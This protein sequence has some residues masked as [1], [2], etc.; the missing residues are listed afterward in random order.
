MKSSLCFLSLFSV[1]SLDAQL[2]PVDSVW[3]EQTL[4]SMSLDEK[5]GQLIMPPHLYLDESKE[6]IEKYHVGGFWFAKSEAVRIA[7][8]LNALQ[9]AS[10]YPLL[11]AAD[12]EKGAGT[13]VDGATDLPINMALGASR[14]PELAYRAAALTA[15]EA[16]AIGVHVNFAP[17]MDVNNNPDNPVINIRSYGEDPTLVAGLAEAA[18]RGYQ[19]NG[20]LATGKH[21]PGHGNTSV[22]SH[23]R[24]G[25]IE[26]NSA[27]MDSLE[28]L[29]Y[30]EVLKKNPPACIMSAHLWVKALDNDTIPATFS[31]N[32]L[33]LLLRGRLGFDGIIFPDAMVMGGLTSRY[34]SEE[35][36][37]R[38]IQAGC[39][40]LLWPPN[41]QTSFETLK[42]AVQSGDVSVERINQSVR[43]ILRA[44]TCVGLQ[45]N[46]SVDVEKIP[47]LVG[48]EA[49]YNEA[50]Q[51]AAKCL[52]LVKD[53]GKLLPLNIGQHVLV[54][55]MNN[56]GGNAMMS[57]TLVSFPSEL[58]NIS[59]RITQFNLPETI[60]DLDTQRA[61]DL[62]RQ[63]DVVVIA[64]YVRIFLG[65]GTVGLP[66]SQ[67]AFIEQMAL[68]NVKVVVV[69]FGNPYIGSSLPFVSTYVCAYDNAKALQ[70]TAAEALF[71]RSGF[72]GKLPVTISKTMK[73]G[74]GI[75]KK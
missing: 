68:A 72:G 20:I 61:L 5:I 59:P 15:K 38:T 75:E 29:P 42:N 40:I 64:A 73:F 14:D 28:L 19:Q 30:T 7:R 13:H 58:S 4:A 65:S 69:S 23:S 66:A 18:I 63:S 51:I 52:T 60:T 10:K 39:D 36:S 41:P 55:T 46:R 43:R 67:R 35:A 49:N 70:Q 74:D 16:R 31:R 11:I 2:L 48:T 44:K 34:T 17:V 62:A 45:K 8:E 71:G 37:L 50:K 32:A 1:F 47:G 26:G 57:R 21:F 54:V 25:I 27:E 9:Q 53:D 22:D 12:F 6:L 33:T 24:L 3:V 56:S